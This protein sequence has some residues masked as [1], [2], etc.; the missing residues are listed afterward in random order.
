MKKKFCVV[1]PMNRITWIAANTLNGIALE[2]TM[3][4]W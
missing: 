1:T 2:M 3:M 4:T